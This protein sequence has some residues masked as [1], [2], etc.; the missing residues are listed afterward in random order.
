MQHTF[1]VVDSKGIH[2]DVSKTERGAKI[3]ATRNGYDKVSVRFNSGFICHVVAE[4]INGKWCKN[5]SE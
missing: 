2:V 3:Y 1:G 5:K 4:K